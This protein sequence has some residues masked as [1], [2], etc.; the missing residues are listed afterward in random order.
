MKKNLAGVILALI[1]IVN[2]GGCS[3]DTNGA[4]KEKS[5]RP[6]KFGATYMNMNN[7]YFEAL[8]GSIQEVVEANGDIL[9][10]RDP[11]QNQEKQ[12]EEIL[13][14]LEEGVA[15]IFVNP[16]DWKGIT[17]ALKAC[18]EAGVPVFDVDTYPYDLSFIVSSIVSDNYN[19]G[20]EIAKNMMEK[21]DSAKIV[22]M[23]HDGIHSTN[24]R[25]QGFSDTIKGHP[26][27]EIVLHR[28]STA[29]LEVAMEAMDGIIERNIEFD[30]VLGGNDPT[31]LGALA[32]LQQHR[33]EKDI[34][35]YGIDGSP[36]GKAMIKEGYLDGSSAQFP[37][38]IGRKAAEVAYE[39][40]SGKSVEKKIIIPVELITSQNLDKFD[41]TGWQ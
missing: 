25:V 10:W 19:A 3:V 12:N 26:S 1:V 41:I 7:P 38:K 16:V 32:A 34:L 9:I 13:E 17:P 15:A 36:D 35:L 18:K 11:L 37:Y 4:A 27:Y 14:F 24:Q 21:R 8:N 5:P 39:Y 28:S 22:I 30:V 31:A 20:V 2:V 33:V 29:E 6:K 23:N 40:L